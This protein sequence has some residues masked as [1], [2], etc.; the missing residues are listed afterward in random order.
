[1]ADEKVFA[2]SCRIS[3]MVERQPVK[4]FVVGSSPSSYANNIFMAKI[5]SSFFERTLAATGVQNAVVAQL[6]RAGDL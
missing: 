1:M 2:V 4:L 3:S 5:L 6:G